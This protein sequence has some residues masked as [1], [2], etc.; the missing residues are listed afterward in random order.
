MWMNLT[1]QGFADVPR[2]LQ[3]RT[4]FCVMHERS[5]WSCCHGYRHA[6]KSLHTTL[7]SLTGLLVREDSSY[8]R[9]VPGGDPF[10]LERVA[11][12]C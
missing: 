3:H 1:Q 6:Q 4:W 7:V 9:A 12:C 2:Q 11:F 8:H 10:S 5:I